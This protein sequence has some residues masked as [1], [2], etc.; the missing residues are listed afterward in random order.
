[1][2]HSSSY[3]PFMFASSSRSVLGNTGDE[4][5]ED[6]SPVARMKGRRTFNKAG[7]EVDLTESEVRY[8]LYVFGSQ[9]MLMT[10]AI[11]WPLGLNKSLLQKHNPPTSRN[12]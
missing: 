5:E 8:P 7:K 10:L 3:L 11:S 2:E 12:H 6:E 9:V 1:M 4:E